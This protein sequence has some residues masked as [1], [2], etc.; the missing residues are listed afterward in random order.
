M[1]LAPA[2]RA[3]SQTRGTRTD[4]FAAVA[5][6]TE[7][8]WMA[9][10]FRT[11]VLMGV[12]FG[13]PNRAAARTALECYLRAQHSELE[14]LD[15]VGEEHL[16]AEIAD[17]VA[18]LQAYSAGEEVDFSDVAIDDGHLTDFGRKIV[19]ACRRIAR[20]KTRSY[21]E[22][23]AQCGS[24]GA[25]RAV[26]QVMAR[27]RFPLVVPCHRVLAAGGLIGG[28]SAPQGLA[29]KRRLLALEQSAT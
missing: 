26:G 22:L 1:P 25:A 8:G 4:E 2:K 21:G 13:H 12:V 19:R 9:L 24:P 14:L 3:L 27:N 11:G 28:F 29:M 16:P 15:F 10:A 6:D 18:R 5:F 23:A 20:G 7:L 17:V